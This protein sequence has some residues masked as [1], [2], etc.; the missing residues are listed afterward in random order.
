M[1]PFLRSELA[2][3]TAYVPHPEADADGAA[4]R[5]LDRLDA[6]EFPLDL[7]EDLKQKLAWSYQQELEAN[8]YPDGG[9]WE[10]KRA[11]AEYVNEALPVPSWIDHSHV[12]IGNGS[13]ELIRS[14]LITTCLNQQ[15][16]ILVAEPT[17]SMYRITAETLGIPVVAVGRNPDTFEIDCSAAQAAIE[18]TEQNRP[19]I[20]VVFVVHPN[21]PTGNGLTI[22]EQ[23]WLRTLPPDILV[24]IDEAYF[25]FC[26][27]TLAGEIVQRSNWIILRTF[28]KAFRLAAHRVGYAIAGPELIAVLE[29]IRLPY[30]L[31]AYSQLAAQLA[32][33]QRQSLLAEIEL[34]WQERNRLFQALAPIPDLRLW[35]SAANFIYV[36]MSTEAATAQLGRDLKALGT[37]IRYTGGGLRISVGT[38]AEN[39][40]TLERI[41]RLL[42][43]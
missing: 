39:D 24:V 33:S 5:G 10:L 4:A 14:L 21:S 9:H 7:P 30:N 25:E 32:L 40:R 18:A 12:S 20:R 37:S 2:G 6:N 1:L 27:S 3:L 23:E 8:R 38:V 15:G 34:I 11:I 29:K 31:P 43:K 13:D 16:A 36:Q 17:F 19:P 42:A 28:S 41:H 35:P 22:A 26:R